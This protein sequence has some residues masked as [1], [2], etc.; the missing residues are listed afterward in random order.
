MPL[1]KSNGIESTLLHSLNPVLTQ[2]DAASQDSQ[3]YA[4]TRYG[5]F[6]VL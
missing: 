2:V 3:P 1:D 4:P 5:H 6:Q